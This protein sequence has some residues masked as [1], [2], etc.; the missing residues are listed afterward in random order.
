MS[1][2]IYSFAADL[3]KQKPRGIKYVFVKKTG[4]TGYSS[5]GEIRNGKAN[6]KSLASKNTYMQSQPFSAVAEYEFEMKQT[7]AATLALLPS[8]V[9]GDVSVIIQCVDDQYYVHNTASTLLGIQFESKNDNKIDENRFVLIQMRVGIKQSELATIMP[10]GAPTVTTPGTS[11]AFWSIAN[12]GSNVDNVGN[13]NQILP[14]G[15][16]KL[17]LCAKSESSYDDAGEVTGSKLS[18]K[19]FGT[20]S[21]K[22]R[23]RPVGVA[24]SG[25]FDLMQDS[26]AEKANLSIFG[27]S[28]VKAKVTH[29]D[30]LVWDL[31]H[32]GVMWNEKNE[33]DFDGHK[34]IN[35]NFDGN[36]LVADFHDIMS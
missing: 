31:Q 21:D 28:G 33:G 32:L 25:S 19:C 16:S 10:S 5:I 2:S 36:I 20:D 13:L 7:S 30:G 6:V 26:S 35:L 15:V 17:E 22:M 14:A 4:D 34:F 3:T 9:A 24:I 1:S 11:D 8:L 23:Y 12:T 27:A 18:F 29:F